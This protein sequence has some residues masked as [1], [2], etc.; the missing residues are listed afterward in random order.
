MTEKSISFVLSRYWARVAHTEAT[1]ASRAGITS[2]ENI[3]RRC[4]WVGKVCRL[5]NSEVS[6]KNKHVAGIL[7]GL[8]DQ[9][10][11]CKRVAG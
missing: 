6:S 11:G 1:A 2:K 5:N 8:I 10:G 3:F 7:P 9:L 4:L